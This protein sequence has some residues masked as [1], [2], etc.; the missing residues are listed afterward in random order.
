MTNYTIKAGDTLTRIANAHNTTVQ[1]LARLNNISDPEKIIA[2]RTIKLV[3]EKPAQ[4]TAQQSNTSEQIQEQ[5]AAAQKQLTQM[6]NQMNKQTDST[7]TLEMFGYGMAGVA[8]YELGKKALP[9]AWKGAKK[10]AVE[11]ANA[12]KKAGSAVA[13]GTKHTSE[14]VA[15]AAKNTGSKI[16]HSVK[17]GAKK[18]E[19]GY[20]F[21]KDVVKKGA[22]RA[23]NVVKQGAINVAGTAKTISGK[24]GKIMKLTKMGKAVGKRIPVVGVTV[25][26]VETYQAGKNGG[27]KAAVKQGVKSASG[28]ACG[29]AGA[30]IGALAGACTGPAAPV[31]VPVLSAFGAVA[32]Y[33]GGEKLMD[34][35]TSWFE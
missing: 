25:A 11:T 6:Q 31:A 9:Y 13:A 12:A 30:K 34:T 16:A 4:Q 28:L 22:S 23:N 33:L 35:V 17:R 14:K 20:T 19:L 26:A 21:G 1:E 8:T 3:E 10:T 24:S 5:L 18:V 2:G 7:S 32:G 27:A 15:N 29:A